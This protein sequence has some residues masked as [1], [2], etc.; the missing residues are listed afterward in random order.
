MAELPR[1]I[2]TNKLN[3]NLSLTYLNVY[4][5]GLELFDGVGPHVILHE[6]E[7]GAAL[8]LAFGDRVSKTACLIPAEGLGPLPN[9]KL[10]TSILPLNTANVNFVAHRTRDQFFW[11]VPYLSG[12]EIRNEPLV[13]FFL[14]PIPIFIEI[15]K[16]VLDL[17][18]SDAYVRCMLQQLPTFPNFQHFLMQKE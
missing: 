18:H 3:H 1:R 8:I 5:D 11:H 7:A 4:S 16:Y 9:L 2:P 17:L 12:A 14:C 13:V 10:I 15:L 6:A